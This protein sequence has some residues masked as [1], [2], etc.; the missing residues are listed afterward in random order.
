MEKVFRTLKTPLELEPVRHR[1]ERRV[2]AYLFVC[3]LAYRLIAA[4]RWRLEEVGVKEK[5]A[6]YQERLLEELA[7]VERTEV[8]LG[9]QSRMWYLNKTDFIE[10]A[11][12]KLGLKD[13]LWEGPPKGPSSSPS[14]SRR[15]AL[16]PG[17]PAPERFTPRAS[18][19]SSPLRLALPPG[20]PLMALP[21]GSSDS[22]DLSHPPIPLGPA[23]PSW[24]A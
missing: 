8:S 17:S 5:T 11:L 13:L 7:R 22:E 15:P 24:S 21:A 9:G 4:L 6:E 23:P 2:R 10:Q 14:A 3:M 12:R 18:V 20:P 1:R 19:P 16:P